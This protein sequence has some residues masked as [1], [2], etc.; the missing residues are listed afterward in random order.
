M[1]LIMD[2]IFPH[3]NHKP[4]EG[5]VSPNRNDVNETLSPSSDNSATTSGV[6]NA[7]QVEN[8]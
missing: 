2:S 6:S 7:Q 5:K 8:G 4:N 1:H 3:A